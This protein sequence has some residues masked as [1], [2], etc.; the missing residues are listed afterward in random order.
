M[1]TV[2]AK[3]GINFFSLIL[4]TL[5]SLMGSGETK[6]LAMTAPLCQNCKCHSYASKKDEPPNAWRGITPLHSTRE[7]VER[8]LGT[9]KMSIG[10]TSRYE[11]ECETVDVLF[12][13]GVCELSGVELWKVPRDTVIWIEVAPATKLFTKDLKLDPNRYVRQR[14]SH[15]ENWVEYRSVED[16]VRVNTILSKKEEFVLWFTY[17]PRRKDNDLRCKHK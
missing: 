3:R 16:G 7:Q 13:K 11:S 9:H 1:R 6:S 2:N 4:L 12:S 10:A 17:E 5:H 14:E 8:L 15:P